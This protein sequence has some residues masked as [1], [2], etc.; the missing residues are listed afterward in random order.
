MRLSTK[1]GFLLV[2]SLIT[3]FITCL[4][5]TMCYTIFHSI[6]IHEKSYLEYQ[7]E[8]NLALEHIYSSLWF[9]EECKI[10]ESD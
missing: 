2:D 5:C 6:V 9:C 1:K 3:V 7:N 4:L 8:S 10:D